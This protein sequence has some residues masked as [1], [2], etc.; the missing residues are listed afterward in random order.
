MLPIGCGSL[1]SLRAPKP[2]AAIATCG[3]ASPDNSLI[4]CAAWALV[5]I[6]ARICVRTALAFERFAPSTFSSPAAQLRPVSSIC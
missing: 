3:F 5:L 6:S 1:R 4:P 2:W